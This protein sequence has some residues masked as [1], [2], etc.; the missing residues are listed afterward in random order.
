MV[1]AEIAKLKEFAHRYRN[2]VDAVRLPAQALKLLEVPK[3]VREIE[4]FELRVLH[5]QTENAQQPIVSCSCK[6]RTP[7]GSD[8]CKFFD[9]F[10][11]AHISI[12]PTF[13][14]TLKWAFSFSSPAGAIYPCGYTDPSYR[15]VGLLSA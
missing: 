15:A 6:T 8:F 4:V 13:D 3:D 11:E 12:K 2:E 7:K 10:A 14:A 5:A 9:D 1:A